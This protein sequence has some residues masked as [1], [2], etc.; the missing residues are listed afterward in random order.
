L[1]NYTASLRTLAIWECDSI[2]KFSSKWRNWRKEYQGGDTAGLG[3]VSSSPGHINTALH[4]VWTVEII[5][6]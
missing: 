5:D 6:K 1:K 2:K 3:Q 4:L